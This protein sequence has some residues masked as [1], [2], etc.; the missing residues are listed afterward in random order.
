M[1][2]GD[3]QALSYKKRRA[4]TAALVQ[5]YGWVCCICGLPIRSRKDLTVQHVI[6]QSKGGRTTFENCRPAH[7]SCNYG[8]R[9][10]EASGPVGLVFDGC[11]AFE[12]NVKT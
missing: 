5:R 6:P 9:D 12:R 4:F 2:R 10:R 11:A 1:S 8:M 7:A 3:W